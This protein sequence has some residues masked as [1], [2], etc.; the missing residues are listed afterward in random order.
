MLSSENPYDAADSQAAGDSFD[1]SGLEA[2]VQDAGSV[3]DNTNGVTDIPLDKVN[4]TG[5]D[6]P[7]D[8][9]SPDQYAGMYREAKMLDQM[10]PAL[11]QGADADTFDAWDKAN[12]IGNSSTDSY[13]RGYTD[14][15]HTYY[16]GSE[17]VAVE[18]R[19]DGTYDV[20]NGRHRIFAARQAGLST[21]PAKVL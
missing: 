4:L 3:S 11:A 1:S 21:I 19:P 18:R 6:S 17:V 2:R 12:Q 13:V 8:F 15:Y 5:V 10:Q 16:D 7:A 20:T 14:V 9:R